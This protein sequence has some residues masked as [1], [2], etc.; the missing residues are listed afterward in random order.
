MMREMMK[1][2][3]GIHCFPLNQKMLNTKSLY[4]IKAK[5]T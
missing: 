5:S 3:Q 4:Q 2:W 1:K